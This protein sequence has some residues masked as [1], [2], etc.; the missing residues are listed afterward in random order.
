[1]ERPLDKRQETFCIIERHA[2]ARGKKLPSAIPFLDLYFLIN[3]NER[4]DGNLVLN[5]HSAAVMAAARFLSSAVDA[6]KGMTNLIF[7][8]KL[9]TFF[10]ISVV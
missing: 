3:I 9:S 4:T 7:M 2:R 6:L 5:L 10:A 1:M 8:R